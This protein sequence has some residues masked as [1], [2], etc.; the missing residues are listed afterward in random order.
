[1]HFD[2]YG[3][4]LVTR[5]QKQLERTV[6]KLEKAGLKLVTRF[7]K[8]L[9]SAVKAKMLQILSHDIQKWTGPLS[10]INIFLTGSI[11]GRVPLRVT[12]HQG[13]SGS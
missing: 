5:F 6:K 10:I 1:M 7:Q 2:V 4:R 11:G 3:L 9:E 12:T 8:Q 13:N